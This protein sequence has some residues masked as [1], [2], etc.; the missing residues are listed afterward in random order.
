MKK[1]MGVILLALLVSTSVFAG[2][3]YMGE[4]HA[5]LIPKKLGV[6]EFTVKYGVSLHYARC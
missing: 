2:I 5:Q 6:P 3:T 1:T 4:V